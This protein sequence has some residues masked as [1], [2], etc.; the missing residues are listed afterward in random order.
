MIDVKKLITGFLI[1]ATAATCSG[2]IF[3]FVNFAPSATANAAPQVTIG[4]GNVAADENA[5][6]P[7]EDQVQQVAQELEPELASS[8]MMVTST[9]PSNLTEDLATGF[10]N[11][12]VDANPTGPTG[13]DS[14][15]NP[16]FNTPDMSA[17]GL[18]VAD[19]AQNVSIPN[20]NVEAAA[21]P[22][23]TISTSSAAALTNYGN[24][25]YNTLNNH[26]SDN[27]RVQSIV[28]EDPTSGVSADELAYVESQVQ[29]TLQDISSLKVP[30]PAVAYQK[31][32]LTYLVYEKNMADLNALAQTDPVKASLIFQGEQ[33]NFTAAQQDLLN[34]AQALQQNSLSLE[35]IP[36]PQK[37][38]GNILLS[39]V[40]ETFGIPKAQ[41]LLP[42]FDPVTWGLITSNQL[43]T[44]GQQV[45]AILKNTLLQ[46]L[47]NTLVAII[48]RKVL[49]WVQGS[50]APRFI[51]NWGT[52]LVNAAQTTAINAINSDITSGCVY[53]AFAPKV[54]ITLK[55]FYTPSNG[56][57]CAN[58]FAASLGAN[59]FQ[60]FYNHFSYGGFVAFG[61]STLPSGNLDATQFFEA[62]KTDLSYHNQ[63]AASNLQTQ[64]GQ[65]FT[66]D[67]YCTDG[68][69]PKGSTMACQTSN[70]G[71]YV[72]PTTGCAAGD[73]QVTVSNGGL[74]AN[75][76]QP[77][78]QTPS[79]VTAFTLNTAGGATTQQITAANDIIGLLN[80]VLSS[81]MLGLANAAVNAAGQ[82]VNQT[83]QGINPAGITSGTNIS[84]VSTSS[85][86]AISNSNSPISTIALA[87]N[88]LS[89]T[90]ASPTQATSTA[91]STPGSLTATS[92]SPASLSATGGTLDA[93]DNPPVYYWSDT[94]GVT[95]TGAFFS[96]TFNTPGTYTI[97]LTDSTGDAPAT[98]AVIQQ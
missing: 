49:A 93:D 63:Q 51:T 82:V 79:A 19:E 91:T 52:T 72:M 80:S 94:N 98:C 96:D 9:D 40:T 54:S 3:S 14:D 59:S 95:S 30:T 1:L 69:N 46:I 90:L 76:L 75:G 10:V 11:G 92:T 48:Q 61:A 20:W 22:V 77:I 68:S 23:A 21:I 37:Q 55:A 45:L 71:Q 24:D 78:V 35:Q 87:C 8:S 25:V 88:P 26:L 73:T 13:T 5:F 60:Q 83:L 50:G 44:I 28:T 84:G 65:G 56:S 74:C 2:I 58:A 27:A 66:G 31:S 34:K 86:T 16:T 70:G 39:F 17:V 32:L 97:T 47:K 38:R 67:Q 81:L 36:V 53:S 6:L 41:A 89:Q 62:Q 29:G 85:V 15:G 18:S 42:V 64:T 4:G 7:T 12:I 33:Q 57:A 43:Q